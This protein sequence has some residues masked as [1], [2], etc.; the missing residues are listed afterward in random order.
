MQIKHHVISSISLEIIPIACPSPYN[1]AKQFGKVIIIS[2]ENMIRAN[3]NPHV[4]N[5]LEFSMLHN[6]LQNWLHLFR[7]LKESSINCVAY[8]QKDNRK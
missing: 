8:K 1:C 4:D 3:K 6:I 2:L 7:Q 5:F